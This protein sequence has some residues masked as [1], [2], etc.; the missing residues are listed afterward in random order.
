MMSVL[1]ISAPAT[2]VAISVV[3]SA[4]TSTSIS[5]NPRC[6]ATR[7]RTRYPNP[8]F[9]A[10]GSAHPGRCLRNRI[11]SSRTLTARKR[12]PGDRTST[13][14]RQLEG[15]ADDGPKARSIGHYG[16]V[17]CAREQREVARARYAFVGTPERP[18]GGRKPNWT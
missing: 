2:A 18:L 12:P 4:L 15:S 8:L 11:A 1:V 7:A 16:W 3:I 9:T 6:E 5:V 14:L 13:P 17:D 10:D